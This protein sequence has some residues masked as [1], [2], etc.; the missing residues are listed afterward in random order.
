MT[1]NE[2][3]GMNVLNYLNLS[4]NHLVG[5]IP[6]STASTKSLTR[7]DFS[8]NNLS[9]LVPGTDGIA[10]S[11]HQRHL[12]GLLSASLKLLIV[13]G[14]LVYSIAS[15]VAAIIK[16]R[17]LKKA[18]ESH[19]WKLTALQRLD[20]TYDDVHSCLKEDNKIGKGG[21]GITCLQRFYAEW[22]QFTVRRLLTVGWDSSHDHG[23]NAEVHTL[24]SAS[25]KNIIK[26]LG[27]LLEL[28]LAG[29]QL[30]NLA[31]VCTLFSGW[32]QKTTD[33]NKEKV[34]KY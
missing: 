31:I 14:L 20:F 17:S 32:V 28:I 13:V 11:S 10:N 33:S 15:A 30:E 5:S 16:K 19:A 9:F 2:I 12:K 25:H 3:T 8:C 1:P 29:N 26:L 6:V 22:L 24:G 4:Q 18:S 34:I 27:V 7:V 23:F 21:A